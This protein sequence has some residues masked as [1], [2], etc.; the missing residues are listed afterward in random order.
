MNPLETGRLILRELTLDDAPF[1][2]ELVNDPAWLRFI[3][4][5]GVHSLEDA[6]ALIQNGP[7]AM[8]AQENFGLWLVTLKP[9]ETPIGLCGLIKRPAFADVD[10]GVA[11]MPLYRQSGYG[12]EAASATLA[13]ARDMVG[14]ERVV[15]I[16]SQDNV[17]SARL[18]QKLG[19]T[20]EDHF[21][22]ENDLE[23]LNLYGFDL[24]R[25][26]AA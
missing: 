20:Y 4:D 11:F 26:K 15:A 9:T 17:G 16:L 14:L 19:F 18:L 5:R 23:I 13:Y 1:I 2:L 8:Y 21:Q 22:F 12:Y 25:D 3:G 7:M 6:R 24:N 10:I